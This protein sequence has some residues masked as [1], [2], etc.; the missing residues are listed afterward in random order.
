MG[1]TLPARWAGGP[2]TWNTILCSNRLEHKT[3]GVHTRQAGGSRRA[4]R[5]FPAGLEEPPA[6]LRVLETSP[7]QLLA[8][9]WRPLA[10]LGYP[11]RSRQQPEPSNGDP[12]ASLPHQKTSPIYKSA[13]DAT[14][15]GP[16]PHSPGSLEQL[17]SPLQQLETSLQRVER[18]LPQVE[19]PAQRLERLRVVAKRVRVVVPTPVG[20][21]AS[22]RVVE[23]TPAEALETLAVVP[24]TP[25]NV[26]SSL[27]EGPESA[28]DGRETGT[29][30]LAGQGLGAAAGKIEG[31]GPAGM[32]AVP[33]KDSW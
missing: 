17:A 31:S 15:D 24:L 10:A 23:M 18:A 22:S 30:V 2:A 28:A 4:K 9:E 7:Q 13:R 14:Q 6:S 19:T 21:L 8:S 29:G 1:A 25:A 3:Q 11:L 27:R 26:A 12:P 32:P 33:E 5:P 20:R 16:N